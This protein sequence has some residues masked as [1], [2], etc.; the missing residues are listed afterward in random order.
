M[1]RQPLLALDENVTPASAVTHDTRP[2]HTGEK[3]EAPVVVQD[4]GVSSKGRLAGVL[5][6]KLWSNSLSI[7]KHRGNNCGACPAIFS[8]AW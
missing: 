7:L 1:W 8:T 3:V 5:V 2:Q 6:T 4:S